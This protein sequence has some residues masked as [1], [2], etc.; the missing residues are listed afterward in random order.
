MKTERTKIEIRLELPHDMYRVESET[1]SADYAL[2]QPKSLPPDPDAME[3]G[4]IEPVTVLVVLTLAVLA[5]R[6]LHFVLAKQGHGVLVDARVRPPNVSLLKG[7]PQGF[8][9]IIHS[10]GTTE[11][12]RADDPGNGL[13]NLLGKAL[14]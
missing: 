1:A 5:E 14:K 7:V 4:F 8:I 13:V 3:A 9:V 11:K 2:G 12:V 10:D 6:L